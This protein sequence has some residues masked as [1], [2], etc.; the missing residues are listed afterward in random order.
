MKIWQENISCNQWHVPKVYVIV[1]LTVK[2]SSM[3]G[4]NP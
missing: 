3:R 4:G 1:K 2:G